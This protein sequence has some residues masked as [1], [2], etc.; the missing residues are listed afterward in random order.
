MR[1]AGLQNRKLTFLLNVCMYSHIL[2]L[3]NEKQMLDGRIKMGSN[4][5]IFN[6][7]IAIIDI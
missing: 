5:A 2:K 4:S 1:K 3:R 6:N 7:F